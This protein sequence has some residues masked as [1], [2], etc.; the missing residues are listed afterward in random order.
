MKQKM[1]IRL[2]NFFDPKQGQHGISQGSYVITDK[3]EEFK[4]DNN[5]PTWFAESEKGQAIEVQG[6]WKQNKTSGDW[7]LNCSYGLPVS[8]QGP[9]QNA[10]QGSQ[11]PPQST[12]APQAS[13]KANR[14]DWD[15]KD[16]LERAK[17]F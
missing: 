8:Q 9:P 4:C 7:Y 14:P 15:A 5:G 11:Q 13:N 1:T 10:Q 17:K 2:K 16:E 6:E 3:G 12:N